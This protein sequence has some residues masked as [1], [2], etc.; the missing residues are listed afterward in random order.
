MYFTH[1]EEY[2]W[3][4]EYTLKN[5]L[6]GFVTRRNVK[7]WGNLKITIVLVIGFLVVALLLC[8]FSLGKNKSPNIVY[9]FK[10]PKKPKKKI[11]PLKIRILSKDGEEYYLVP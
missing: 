11:N 6:G 2:P 8:L 7:K 9:K 1:H 3:V 10:T 4:K 5:G